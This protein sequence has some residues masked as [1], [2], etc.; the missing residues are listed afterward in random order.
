MSVDVRHGDC[1]DHLRSL[2]DESVDAC[3][4]D[5]PYGLG[6]EPPIVDVMTAWLA[7]EVYK[8]R[9]AGFMGREWDAYVPGPEV[10]REVFRV[11]KPGGHLLSFFGTRT[12]DVGTLSIRLA[13]FEVRDQ[14]DWLYGQGF[15]KSLDVSKAIDKEAGHWRGRAGAVTSENGSMGG[16]NYERTDK[17]E[18]VTDEAAQWEGWG[19]ALKPAHE[20]IVLARKP[21]AAGTV[22]AQVLASGTGAIN[23]DGCRIP[24][25]DNLNGV[26]YSGG[27]RPRAAMGLDGRAGGTGSMLEAGG[28]R[29]DPSKFTQPI[30][31][32]PANVVLDEEAGAMLDAQSGNLA[33][34]G[35]KGPS[36]RVC[37]P[38]HVFGM[39]HSDGD[40][41]GHLTYDSGGGASRFFYCAKASVSERVADGH[42]TVKPLSLMR[43]LVRLVTPPGGLVVDPFG[44]SGTTALACLAE[45]MSCIVMEREAKYV[46]VI[47]ERLAGVGVA[48]GNV[49]T[50]T[51][52]DPKAGQMG[53]FG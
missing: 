46:G 43:W 22:A 20:P 13:G 52:R 12:Y 8:P 9:G 30:G 6:K 53:L 31:R 2:A 45:G 44:G 21:L 15:P 1:L 17:G 18:P 3:V 28:G 33:G 27:S 41:G 5:A 14:I 51:K 39:D 7:G 24:T 19:T 49:E 11:L 10:W 26:A 25:S 48:V 38:D 32:W 40:C 29:L 4:T 37:R 35:N 36:K 16:P 47:R 34:R 23:V 50:E 42:E